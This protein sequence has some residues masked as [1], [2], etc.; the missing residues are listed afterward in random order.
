MPD[1]LR[2]LGH[3]PEFVGKDVLSGQNKRSQGRQAVHFTLDCAWAVC[4]AQTADELRDMS[5]DSE[6]PSYQPIG[7]L[8]S[9]SWRL[10]KV[11]HRNQ[12]TLDRR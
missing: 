3:V 11:A 1:A 10:K 12:E 8:R 2:G 9:P 7:F 5:L 4:Y 6:V